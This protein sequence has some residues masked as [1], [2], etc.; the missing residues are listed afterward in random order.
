MF[1]LEIALGVFLGVFILPIVAKFS[2]RSVRYVPWKQLGKSAL[3][4]IIGTTAAS[5][6]LLG[7]IEAAVY[8]HQSH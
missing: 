5:L 8:L 2:I 7:I 1:V 3:I 6:V 4:V